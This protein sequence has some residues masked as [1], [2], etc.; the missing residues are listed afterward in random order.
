MD[1]MRTLG[2]G[3]IAAGVDKTLKV[4]GKKSGLLYGPSAGTVASLVYNK[5]MYSDYM[6]SCR[7][8]VK[9]AAPLFKAQWS[10]DVDAS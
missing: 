6:N 5:P 8:L 10:S 1:I 3:L 2:V 7:L 9:S 4:A